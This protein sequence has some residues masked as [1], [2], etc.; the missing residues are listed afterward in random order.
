MSGII[1]LG[2][3]FIKSKNQNALIQWY[4]EVL[5]LKI[6]DWGGLTFATNTLKE[7]AYQ[8]FS[9]FPEDTTYFPS[10]QSYL[11]NFMVDDLDHYVEKLKTKGI[12][13]IKQEASDYGKFAWINDIDSN[14]IELWQM[15]N[16][17]I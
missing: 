16:S 14:K 17:E 13:I 12:E 7:D 4:K 15:P 6:E 3:I 2:G 9:T 10:N 1:G 11:I 8:L 5:E